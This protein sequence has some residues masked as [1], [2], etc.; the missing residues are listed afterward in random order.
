MG[1][2]TST[3]WASDS[4]SYDGN[5]VVAQFGTG[6]NPCVAIITGIDGVNIPDKTESSFKSKCENISHTA[7]NGYNTAMMLGVAKMFKE[8]EKQIDGTV[9]IIFQPKHESEEG[10]QQMIKEGVL[11]QSPQVDY[12]I[13]AQIDTKYETGKIVS[14]PGTFFGYKQTFKVTIQGRGGHSGVQ[15][16]AV[17]PIPPMATLF[18]KLSDYYA[19]EVHFMP[20]NIAF[21]T[22]GDVQSYNNATNVIP[23]KTS[24]TGTIRT[25]T[26]KAMEDS[27]KRITEMA[28]NIAMSYN[29]NASFKKIGDI[30]PPIENDQTTYKVFEEAVSTASK[31]IEPSE[32]Q[33]ISSD[34]SYYYK[35]VPGVHFI[36]G[37]GDQN[38]F[39]MYSPYFA[40]DPNSLVHG[41]AMITHATMKTMNHHNKDTEGNKD[42]L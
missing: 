29:C 16:Y 9:K 18:T 19:R 42:E 5:G 3:G 37:A 1:A 12:M 34:F 31:K 41:A 30:T 11:T 25:Y 17:D 10:A 4:H 40:A 13:G 15:T 27:I 2:S 6:K 38:S 39:P 33:L 21:V 8:A 36:V 32:P 20:E 7:G 26:M 23:D 22:V 28:K 35:S 14:T 24:M